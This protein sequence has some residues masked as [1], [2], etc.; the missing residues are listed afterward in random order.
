MPFDPN[1]PPYKALNS[2]AKMREQ[3]NSLKSLIDELEARVQ[4]L[5]NALPVAHVASGFGDARAN[6]VLMQDGMW[7]GYP[8]YRTPSGAFYHVADMQYYRCA[9][10]GDPMNTMD[11]MY[12]NPAPG[13]VAGAYDLNIGGT[14]PAGTVS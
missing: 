13:T 9:P 1:W 5:E 11:V 3:F 12:V 10:G 6:G 14:P 8:A 2:S 7:N 4:A